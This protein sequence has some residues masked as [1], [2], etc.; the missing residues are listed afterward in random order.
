MFLLDEISYPQGSKIFVR[1]VIA[2]KQLSSLWYLQGF[3][4]KNSLDIDP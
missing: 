1:M 3:Y 2:R 4:N